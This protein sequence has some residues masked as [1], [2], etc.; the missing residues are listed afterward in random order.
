MKEQFW[1]KVLLFG[2]Y[3]MIFDSTALLI[4]LKLF[5]AKWAC[6]KEENEPAA[7]FSRRELSLFCDFLQARD[8]LKEVI[9]TEAFEKDLHDGWWLAS[10]VPIGYG[11]GSSGTVTAAVYDRYAG[12]RIKDAMRLKDL[13]SQMESCFHGSSSGIARRKRPDLS[14]SGGRC[15]AEYPVCEYNHFLRTADQAFPDA[16]GC[17]Q[18][19]AD[20]PGSQSPGLSALVRGDSRRSCHAAS[21]R[22]TASV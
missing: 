3:S 11:L 15:R 21:G 5:S 17:R 16:P 19:M 14:D 12:Y 13:F 9:D 18:G 7:V 6:A 2:E 1:S 10:N 20:G 8:R 4:P 22:E